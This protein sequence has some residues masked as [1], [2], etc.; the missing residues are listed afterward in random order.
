MRTRTF[1][2]L[3]V[4]SSFLV[5]ATAVMVLAPP[6]KWRS[7]W[8]DYKL[9]QRDNVPID[10]YGKVE[11][12]DGTPISGAT[13][14]FRLSRIDPHLLSDRD[15]IAAETFQRS[16]DENG[17]FSA[18]GLIGTSLQVTAVDKPGYRSDLKVSRSFEYSPRFDVRTRHHA[19]PA[20]PIIFL[21]W[22]KTGTEA[23]VQRER[24]FGVRPDGTPITIDLLTGKSQPARSPTGDLLVSLKRP[25]G[26][27]YPSSPFEWEFEIKGVNAGIVET[28]EI[29]AYEAPESGYE[30][31]YKYQL[32]TTTGEGGYT[33]KR[34]YYVRG[35]DG[36]FYASL[37]VVANSNA[38]TSGEAW[39]AFNMKYRLNPRGS[40]N[41][42]PKGKD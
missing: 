1:C 8:Y 10:F 26:L 31:G 16:T 29:F 20:N 11:Q 5:V 14:E 4:C 6:W 25:E 37:E 23:L 36:S 30:S 28:K 3:A 42:E 17:L 27:L 34:K 38:D 41:L 7:R 35:R 33:E 18:I 15:P 40:R 12:Q 2:I 39:G 24:T 19:D 13:V 32:R 22:K 9:A 21:M